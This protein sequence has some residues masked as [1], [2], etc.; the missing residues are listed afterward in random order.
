MAAAAAKALCMNQRADEAIVVLEA[1]TPLS[2]V[3]GIAHQFEANHLAAL[4][5]AYAAAGR[6]PEALRTAESAIA[7]AQYSNSQVWEI[8]AWLVLL[9]LPDS[10]I[11]APRAADGVARLGE[12]IRVSGAAGYLPWWQ[13]AKA[14]WRTAQIL[15]ATLAA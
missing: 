8:N 11:D 13:A 7:S 10:L 5:Q 1:L 9:A 4:A 14:R 3:D 2:A 12:L 6:L 15:S